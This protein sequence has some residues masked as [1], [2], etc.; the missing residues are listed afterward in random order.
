MYFRDL[1]EEQIPRA[2]S[3]FVKVGWLD[4]DKPYTQG[5]CPKKFIDKLKKIKLTMHTRGWNDCPFC[6]NAKSSAEYYIPILPT[7]NRKG[8]HSPEM[9]IHYITEHNYLPPQEFIDAVMAYNE[10]FMKERV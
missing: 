10:D 3:I 1:F 5:E 8:Y 4:K 7:K 9:I 2:N 6:E